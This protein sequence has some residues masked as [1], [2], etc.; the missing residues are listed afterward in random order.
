MTFINEKLNSMKETNTQEEIPNNTKN[1]SRFLF[2]PKIVMEKLRSNIFGQDHVLN[3]I[4]NMLKVVKADFGHKEKPL[5]VI[6]MVGPTGVGKT[7]TVKILS[8]AIYG[9]SHSFCRID[10]NTLAQEHYAAALTGAPP[11]YVGSK[12]GY[13]LFN[14]DLIQGS[15]SKPGIVLFDEIE[16]ASNEVIRAILN[17]LDTGYLRLSTGTKE[18]DFRNSMIF[19]TSNLGAKESLERWLKLS[20]LPKM[21]NKV[22]DF[23][24]MNE[25][26]LVQHAIHKKFDLEFLNRIDR[27]LFF[28]RIDVD[29][30]SQ[31][32]N[33]EIDKLNRR[34]SAKGLVVKLTDTAIQHLNQYYDVKY[35]IRGLSRSIK[36]VIEPVIAAY[37]V[38]TQQTGKLII[39]YQQERFVCLPQ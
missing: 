29:T 21:F 36:T 17:V 23:L 25:Q 35:G 3:E 24:N 33:L 28:N 11:G 32:V 2:E 37:Y 15:F 7:E 18:I 8:E 14:T 20:K 12:E 39:D 10:M 9:N 6:L 13:T 34:L 38:D 31:V 30:F 22:A 4:E 19:M 26:V 16:K 5:S 1:V 27:I